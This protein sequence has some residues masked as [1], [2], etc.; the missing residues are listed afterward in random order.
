VTVSWVA[1]LDDG[2]LVI[3]EYTV[4]AI[5]GDRHCTTD[6][7]TCVV[8]GL[9]NGTAYRFSVVATNSLGDGE[10]GGPSQAVTPLADD[11]PVSPDPTDEPEPP[12]ASSTAGFTP[13]ALQRLFDTRP[14]EP[15]G[16]VTVTKQ[17]YGGL[18][19]LTV[20]VTGSA[21]VPETGVAA[22]SLNLTAVDS[23]GP[24]FAT[25]FPCGPR[26]LA[27]NLN[28]VAGDVVPNLVIAPVSPSGEVCVFA[29]VDTHLVADVNGWFAVGSGF[30]PLVPS[31]LFDTRVDEPQ[32]SVI[33][34]KHRY[35]S[36]TLLTVK[37]IGAAGI[38][39]TDVGAVSLNVTA[40]LPQAPG[41]LTVFPCGSR[42]LASNLNFVTGDVVPNLVIA[43][44]SAAGEVCVF[45][46][47]DT[48]IVADVTGWF[49]TGSEFSAMVPTRLFDT[50][51]GEPNG[52]VGVAKQR[53][54]GSNVLRVRV[55]G[56][57]DIP[58]T[59]VRAVSLNVTAVDPVGAGY[60]TVF[61]CGPVP[62][63]S[64]LNF[65]AGE[66]KPNSV[67]APVSSDGDI[68]LFASV[69]S[70]LVADVNGWFAAD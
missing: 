35:G 2:G 61:A 15:Q 54:G 8:T 42:P 16:A 26:P 69:D 30:N 20:K 38:P 22:V 25:V 21:D 4:T 6:T 13:L 32:G 41:F 14:T 55:L 12:P 17:R 34:A 28:F 37:V 23:V 10:A 39:P 36:Q 46:S 11:T 70:H 57:A 51:P 50:R 65:D 49:A 44:V 45:A 31:R 63:A 7:T 67:I 62:L 64:H 56:V 48:D 59:G 1:P 24:G 66:I 52:A 53:F 68:C 60:V 9:T 5:P 40:V 29:S 19:V 43:P 18:K 27:S 33:V 47:G 58:I 3:T